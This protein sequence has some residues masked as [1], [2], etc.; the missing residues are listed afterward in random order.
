MSAMAENVMRSFYRRAK[1]DATRL[2]WHRE[3]PGR[4][5]VAAAGSRGEQGRALDVGC[6]AGVFS[7]WLSQR[8]LQVTAID[9]F[10]EAIEMA[11]SHAAKARVAI[12]LVTTDLFAFAPAEPYD[13]VFDSGCMH[14]LV[15]GD[16]DAYKRQVLA[17]LKPGGDFVLE[18]WGKRHALDWRPIG[19]RRRSQAT[20]ER[21]FSPELQLRE[22]DVTDFRAPLPFGPTVRGIGYWFRRVG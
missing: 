4:L 9:M 22:S 14:S 18:H 12:E 19:P 5:L 20:I 3:A 21:I 15:G 13:L 1:G 2:P 16:V 10:P 17:W 6:G 11:R 8:G 7:V